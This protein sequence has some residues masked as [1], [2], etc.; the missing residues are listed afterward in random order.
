MRPL[1]WAS[2]IKTQ[3]PTDRPTDRRQ[4]NRPT[5]P[6][7]SNQINK[8]WLSSNLLANTLDSLMVSVA[9]SQQFGPDSRL[10]SG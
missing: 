7:I 10:I 3:P 1:L 5:T 4:I 6:A 2:A 8:L 9:A